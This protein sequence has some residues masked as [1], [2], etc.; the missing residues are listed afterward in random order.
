MRWLVAV[1][2]VFGLSTSVEAKRVIIPDIETIIER[3]ADISGLPAASPPKEIREVS[4]ELI[5]RHTNKRY[6]RATYLCVLQHLLYVPGYK[7]LIPHEIVHMLQCAA[8]LNPVSWES[9]QQAA[10][11]SRIYWRKWEDKI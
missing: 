1:V 7:W 4:A 3:V 11:T 2:F 10:E 8:K 9:E 5:Y 6:A